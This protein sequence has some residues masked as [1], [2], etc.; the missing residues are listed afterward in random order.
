MA[1]L[2][3]KPSPEV[4]LCGWR[5]SQ[6]RGYKPSRNKQTSEESRLCSRWL[7]KQLWTNIIIGQRFARSWETS[8]SNQFF[9]F[10]FLCFVF[11]FEGCGI[12]LSFWQRSA[13]MQTYCCH[14]RTYMH[15]AYLI[16]CTYGSGPQLT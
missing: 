15:L 2:R 14:D 8:Y 3:R 5:G 7:V 6:W 12:I 16:T 13:T 4:T 1:Q 10:C 9:C 11:V